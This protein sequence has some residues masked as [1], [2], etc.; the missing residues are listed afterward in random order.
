MYSDGRIFFQLE[1]GVPNSEGVIKNF[2]LNFMEKG[3][4][5]ENNFT[6]SCL[7]DFIIDERN[8]KFRSQI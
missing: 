2:L 8:F 7:K 5:N 4:F 1:K 6:T 3:I